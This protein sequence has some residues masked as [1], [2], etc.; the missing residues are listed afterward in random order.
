MTIAPHH[1]EDIAA[2]APGAKKTLVVVVGDIEVT[3]GEDSPARLSD[4]DAILFNADTAHRLH[5]PG[6]QEAKAFLVVTGIDG[7]ASRARVAL[8]ACC[9]GEITRYCMNSNMISMSS[10]LADARLSHSVRRIRFSREALTA[11]SDWRPWRAGCCRGWAWW[12]LSHSS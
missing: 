2:H 10:S 7:A 5:N 11:G 9:S 12:L 4:G 1:S 8:K 6:E 3:V